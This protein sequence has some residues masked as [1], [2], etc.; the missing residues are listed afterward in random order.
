[1]KAKMKKLKI[2]T[3]DQIKDEIWQTKFRPVESS[4]IVESNSWSESGGESS[5]G[6]PS[7]ILTPS[8]LPLSFPSSFP[9]PLFHFNVFFIL[10]SL[11]YILIT[12][13]SCKPA[14]YPPRVRVRVHPRV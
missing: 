10:I 14:G 2:Y 8:L 9:T 7:C 13:N 6:L 4:R 3:L 11:I 12:V 1:M 5:P